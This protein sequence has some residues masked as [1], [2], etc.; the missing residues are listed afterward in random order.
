VV[1]TQASTS[2][3]VESDSDLLVFSFSGTTPIIGYTGNSE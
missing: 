3:A 1:S 2:Q